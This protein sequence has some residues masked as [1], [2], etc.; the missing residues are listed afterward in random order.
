MTISK[1]LREAKVTIT[2][3][4]EHGE[5]VLT[6]SIN[7]KILYVGATRHKALSY[8]Q[9]DTPEYRKWVKDITKRYRHKIEASGASK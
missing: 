9:R 4:R 5:Y 2:Y 7:P 3:D 8:F 6:S 1:Q